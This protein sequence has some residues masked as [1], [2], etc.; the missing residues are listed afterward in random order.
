MQEKNH[1]HPMTF[2]GPASTY[3]NISTLSPIKVRI[4]FLSA[5][6][7]FLVFLWLYFL[8]IPLVIPNSGDRE[9]YQIKY[10]PDPIWHVY[11]YIPY[12]LLPL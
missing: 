6:R 12:G 11:L 10:R 9:L 8:S 1:K 4:M 7:I 3:L 2:V 5:C